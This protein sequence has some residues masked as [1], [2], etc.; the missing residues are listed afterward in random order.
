MIAEIKDVGADASNVIAFPAPA[1]APR[2]VPAIAE[3]VS[4]VA[5]RSASICSAL[6]LAGV[7]DLELSVDKVASMVAAMPRGE[8]RT[9]AEA[10]LKSI[11]GQL[12][13]AR[14]LS[15]EVAETSPGS[16]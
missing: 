14:T 7:R 2:P 4:T 8:A 12:D 16:V 6:L 1:A 3:A 15:R 9:R 5:S 10:E 13:T 11:R